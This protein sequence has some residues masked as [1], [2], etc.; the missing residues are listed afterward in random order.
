MRVEVSDPGWLGYQAVSLTNSST[1]KM[2]VVR[3]K[4]EAYLPIESRSLRV[5][6]KTSAFLSTLDQRLFGD[7]E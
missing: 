3:D 7:P 4:L 6:K 2:L 5:G 1:S